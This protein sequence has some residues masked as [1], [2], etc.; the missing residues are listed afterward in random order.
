M[1]DTNKAAL[2]VERYATND[3]LWSCLSPP[4]CTLSLH[5]STPLVI[6]WPGQLGQGCGP[7][8]AIAPLARRHGNCQSGRDCSEMEICSDT[9]D[10]DDCLVQW[11]GFLLSNIDWNV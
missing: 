9:V 2:V 10:F 4:V 1:H 11:L 5:T 7:L 6:G 8:A 3:F